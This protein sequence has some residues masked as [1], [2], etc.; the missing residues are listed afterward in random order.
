MEDM[1]AKCGADVVC[2]QTKEKE[3]NKSIKDLERL[4]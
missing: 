4:L 3:N 2:V 1:Y